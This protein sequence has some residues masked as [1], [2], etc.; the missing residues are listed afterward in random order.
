MF[1]IIVTSAIWLYMLIGAFIH[2]WNIRNRH[3]LEYMKLEQY[4]HLRPLEWI[5]SGVLLLAAGIM[6]LA[7]SNV[8]S[9]SSTNMRGSGDYGL[10]IVAGAIVVIILTCAVSIIG[11]MRR[12]REDYLQSSGA[13]ET[14][15][16]GVWVN[17]RLEAVQQTIYI[18]QSIW[19]FYSLSVLA[20]VIGAGL[21]P[22]PLSLSLMA[23]MLG[24]LGACGVWGAL[25]LLPVGE[26]DLEW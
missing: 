25:W 21:S 16:L 11:G 17:T 7:V 22:S 6:T 5:A 24:L 23:F 2:C 19:K 4:Y 1:Y 26:E 9:I 18:R 15:E 10:L 12:Y 8:W 13:T 14:R 3:Q 20:M